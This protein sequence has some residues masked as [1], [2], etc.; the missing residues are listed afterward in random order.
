MQGHPVRE[1]RGSQL[2]CDLVRRNLLGLLRGQATL[3]F[4]FRLYTSFF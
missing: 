4:L 3:M 2:S 1:G